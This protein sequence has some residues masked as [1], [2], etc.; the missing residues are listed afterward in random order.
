[1]TQKHVPE[2]KWAI[3]KLE[4]ANQIVDYPVTTEEYHFALYEIEGILH[5]LFAKT[6]HLIERTP[7]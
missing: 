6:Q 4:W 7:L 3:E 2:W 1:M 5:P